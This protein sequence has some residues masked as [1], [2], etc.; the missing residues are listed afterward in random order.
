M[1][2]IAAVTQVQTTTTTTT[3]ATR[4]SATRSTATTTKTTT[5]TT[6][7][8]TKTTTKSTT[9]TTTTATTTKKTSTNPHIQTQRLQPLTSSKRSTQKSS[10]T[11]VKENTKKTVG[12]AIEEAYTS[13]ESNNF[14]LS[15]LTSSEIDMV[16]NATAE[17][18]TDVEY[19]GEYVDEDDDYEELMHLIE[20]A[21]NKTMSEREDGP[22]QTTEEVVPTSTTATTTTSTSSSTVQYRVPGFNPQFTT[23]S[24][25]LEYVDMAAAVIAAENAH[26]VHRPNKYDYLHQVYSNLLVEPSVVDVG[27]GMGPQKDFQTVQQQ[28]QQASSSMVESSTARAFALVT[29][30]KANVEYESR[31]KAPFENE[32]EKPADL[33]H[34][35]HIDAITRTEWGNA[36]IFKG[37]HT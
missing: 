15:N 31:P 13:D 37:S 26:L 33:C 35:P 1:A 32:N 24:K 16:L 29:Q 3:K 25:P 11:T 27:G 2:K 10:E 22:A 21:T 18:M 9:T 34:D 23:K 14:D 20:Q 30:P 19:S 36:F 12:A 28:Q 8:T 5:R 17:H 4:K 7:T 6:R